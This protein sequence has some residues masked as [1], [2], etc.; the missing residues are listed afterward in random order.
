MRKLLLLID[1]QINSAVYVDR[2]KPVDYP[3]WVKAPLYP[4]Y[5]N[6]GPGEYSMSDL[7]L[8]LHKNQEDKA[9]TGFVIYKGL[10]EG[11]F[12][13]DCLNLND[14]LAIQAKG[15]QFF[16]AF[17][18]G[19]TVNLWQSVVKNKLGLKFI[20]YLALNDGAVIVCWTWIGH[21]FYTNCPAVFF[22]NA[23][24]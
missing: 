20:P 4:E 7:C 22:K 9:V 19:Q 12:L 23:P 6:S 18:K 15:P 17:F 14:G 16:S 8:L 10:V 13:K 11:D 5:A 1:E 21:K 24:S 3:S 2:S